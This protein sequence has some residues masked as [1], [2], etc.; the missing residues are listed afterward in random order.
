MKIYSDKE[1]QYTLSKNGVQAVREKYNWD[2]EAHKLTDL[3]E[4]VNGK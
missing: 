4:K 1:L 2:H 3:Y